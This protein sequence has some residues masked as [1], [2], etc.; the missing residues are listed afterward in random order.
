MRKTETTTDKAVLEWLD[1]CKSEG[2]RII[3]RNNFWA[4]LEYCTQK[5][6][7]KTGS[8]QLEDIKQKRLS[9]DNTVKFFYDNEMIRFFK[10]L[11]T[12]YKGK[13]GKPL[14]ESYALAMVNCV[15]SFFA[16]HRYTLE[17]QKDKLPTSEKIASVYIDHAFDIYQLRAMF[18]CGDLRERTILACSKDL[19]LRVGDFRTLNRDLI[20]LAIRREKELAENEKR[21]VDI[22]EF[23]IISEKEKEPVSCHLSHETTELLEQYLKTYPKTEKTESLFDLTEEA[24]NDVIKR[25]VEKAKITIDANARVRFHCLRKFG[26]TIMHGQ[27]Q[28]P[29]MKYMTGKHIAKDLKTYIQNNRETYK[30][31]KLLEPLISLTKT[32]GS[33][34]NL[35]KQLE[36]LKKEAFKRVAFQKLLEKIIPKEDMRKAIQEL[37]EEFG[38]KPEQPKKGKNLY[39]F[40]ITTPEPLE[41]FITRLAQKIEAKDLERILAENGNGNNHTES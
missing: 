19:W 23:E 30:A 18:Q 41:A 29:V 5:G 20:E 34:N 22:V 40:D 37:A 12:E 15:R 11:K 6:L 14:S 9:T 16:Y 3:Y 32:N 35:A 27:V 28:E 13:R 31:F 25:L 33:S 39:G 38:L 7:P 36:E 26:I 1:G 8:E 10:W 17:I 24:L 4:W 2:T 21:D